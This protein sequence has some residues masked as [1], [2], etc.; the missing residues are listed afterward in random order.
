MNYDFYQDSMNSMLNRE[1][2]KYINLFDFKN[3]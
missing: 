3:K 1:T 2:H